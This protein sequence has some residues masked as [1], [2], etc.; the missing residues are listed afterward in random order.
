MALTIWARFIISD[1]FVH[2][3]FYLILLAYMYG[4]IR[5]GFSVQWINKSKLYIY[6]DKIASKKVMCG[7]VIKISKY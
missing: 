1:I 4:S 7:F 6:L 5:Q 3:Q 2:D